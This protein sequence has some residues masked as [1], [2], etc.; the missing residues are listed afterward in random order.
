MRQTPWL[1]LFF[2]ACA[3]AL[4]TAGCGDDDDSSTD[5]DADVDV[6][7]D[8]DGDAD[9][10][11]GDEACGPESCPDPP[12]CDD[13]QV[14]SCCVCVRRQDESHPL[15]RTPC[16]AVD[17]DCGPGEPDLGCF[18]PDGYRVAGDPQDVIVYGVTDIF[19][20][21][22]DADDIR[23]EIFEPGGDCGDGP[24][25]LL[26]TTTALVDDCVAALGQEEC[27]EEDPDDEGSF[28][29]LGYFEFTETVPTETILALRTSG[30][31]SLW[32]P[33][34]LYN[35]YFTNDEVSEGRVFYEARVLST[36]D[37]RTIP[38][39]AGMP[40]GI[41]P[42]NGA[43]AGEVHDCGDAR[44]GF[45]Q[46][47]TDPAPPQPYSITYFNDNPDDPLP[48]SSRTE[49]TSILGL[50]ASLNLPPGPA[51][52]SAIGF[53]GDG[54][55]SLGWFDVCVFADTVSAVTLRGPRPQ[56]LPSD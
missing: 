22:V 43:L 37:Y 33:L 49:G 23:V 4:S 42:G 55:V 41:S 15:A 11:A 46:V 50:W 38:A 21:G 7:A 44:V 28:R 47:A 5:G 12:S 39:S 53:V 1:C 14:L 10:V 40:A 17:D 19:G 35:L 3:L 27:Q 25:T 54:M 16:G 31:P 20:N 9:E 24:G 6:D 48:I 56:Q 32:K 34:V 36:D 26:A 52:V 29:D 30:N 13:G 2:A 8:A 45:A 18:Q 51:K